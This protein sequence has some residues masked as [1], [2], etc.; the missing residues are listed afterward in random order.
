VTASTNT[1]IVVPVYRDR[2]EA[3]ELLS[4]SQ[5]ARR[6]GHHYIVL[7]APMGLSVGEYVKILGDREV[8]YFDPA[9]F[10]ARDGGRYSYSALMVSEHFYG[11]FAAW[12]HI[13]IHQTD[14]FVFD[15][16]LEKWTE[17][18]FDYI[19]PPFVANRGGSKV[20]VDGV[21]GGFS[22]RR[23]EAFLRVLRQARRLS[24]ISRLLVPHSNARSLRR[25]RQGRMMEDIYW[26]TA[27]IAVAPWP[28]AVK[29]A[30]ESGL[31]LLK[32]TYR[33]RI[34][35]GCHR[36]WNL[37]YIEALQAGARPDQEPHYE[38]VLH[39]VLE[40]SGNL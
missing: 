16:Q 8:C 29:F 32:N 28:E 12:E 39:G 37:E 4:L 9:F 35:F 3:W 17:S 19:G 20:I 24:G 13:L 25:A 6:L 38:A 15:D 40:R 21:N 33:D 26:S 27:P 34:P 5:L 31:E 30:F 11:R 18:A 2:P 36:R 14:A 22:L 1:C 10:R 7:L 23:V